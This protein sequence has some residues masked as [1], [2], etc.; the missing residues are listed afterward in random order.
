M[1]PQGSLLCSQ[2]PSKCHFTRRFLLASCMHCPSQCCNH[3]QGWKSVQLITNVHVKVFRCSSSSSVGEEHLMGPSMSV[4]LSVVLGGR[5]PAL[6][7]VTV[8]QQCEQRSL[9]EH[10]SDNDLESHWCNNYLCILLRK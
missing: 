9:L 5:Q 1:E 10:L 2:N 7:G 3:Y 8:A 4:C 6:P